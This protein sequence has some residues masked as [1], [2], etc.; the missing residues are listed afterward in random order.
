MQINSTKIFIISLFIACDAVDVD[1]LQKPVIRFE[2]NT[3]VLHVRCSS[4]QIHSLGRRNSIT[5]LYNLISTKIINKSMPNVVN[6]LLQMTAM[7]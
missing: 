4:C 5:F 3:L 1:L 6:I 2:R 7:L